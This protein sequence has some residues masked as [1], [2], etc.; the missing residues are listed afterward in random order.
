MALFQTDAPWK[1]AAGAVKAFEIPEGMPFSKPSDDLAQITTD[2]R[3][4]HIDLVVGVSP[5]TGEGNGEFGKCGY[6][7]EGYGALAGPLSL[8]QHL[9]AVGATP[10]YFDMD[11][12][13]YFGH[14]FDRMGGSFGCRSSI[15]HLALDVATKIR[16]VRS[17]FPGVRFGDVE[18]LTFSDNDPWFKDDAWLADLSAWFDDY[19]AA[20]G[21]KLAFFRIDTWWTPRLPKEM[22]ALTRLLH[23]KQI[24]LQ[25]IYDGNG[26]KTDEAWVASAVAHFKQ[27]EFG[28]WPLPEAAVIQFW[29]PNPS[30]VFPET[31]PL[32]A[33]G[34]IDQ[35]LDWR[36][37]R[38]SR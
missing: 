27:F 11:E 31:D 18:P 38:G 23:A 37:V 14:V 29:G 24:P 22:P 17:V 6:H 8:A 1:R 32:T 25:I 2:L 4:R 19:E 20:V 21:D 33:T 35:Y 15:T 13:L 30:R 12:P 10:R 9:A 36:Q 7:V 34:L 3:R 26:Q 5:L 28:S 16:Q